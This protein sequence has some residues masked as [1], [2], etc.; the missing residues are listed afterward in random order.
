MM[1]DGICCSWI[2]D[3]LQF[4]LLLQCMMGYV[5]VGSKILSNWFLKKLCIMGYVVVGFK[6]I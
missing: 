5:V 1:H 3:Y 6:I 4:V 2:L